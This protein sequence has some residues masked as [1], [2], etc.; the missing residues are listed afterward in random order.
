[1]NFSLKKELFVR[2][3][4]KSK[5]TRQSHEPIK[6]FIKKKE[7]KLKDIILHVR[8]PFRHG[9][10]KEMKEKLCMFT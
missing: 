2:K 6:L 1:M 10:R 8:V 3:I 7:R 9:E 5:S 4:K